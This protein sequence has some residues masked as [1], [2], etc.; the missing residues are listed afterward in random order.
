[1]PQSDLEVEHFSESLKGKKLDVLVSGSIGAIESVRF[2]RAL[3]RLGAQV[4][5]ILSKGASRFVG[6]DALSWAAGGGS[7]VEEFSG[8]FSHLASKDAMVIA[9]ASANA[10]SSLAH[11]LIDFPGYA[12]AASY[13]GLG[14]PLVLVPSMHDSLFTS[15]FI[16]EN[17]R[18][19]S[20]VASVLKSRAEEGKQKFPE[21]MDLADEVSHILN[22][23]WQE[24]AI[25]RSK[26]VAVSMGSTRAYLDDIRYVSNYSSGKLGSLIAEELYRNGCQTYVIAGSCQVYPRVFTE[27]RRCE[28][29]AEMESGIQ[30]ILAKQASAAVCA[31]S[32][33]DFLPS[34]KIPG[35]IKSREHHELS[36]T[37]QRTHKIIE[38][39][40]PRGRVKVGFKLESHLTPEDARAYAFEYMVKYDLSMMVVNRLSDVSLDKH[41]AFIYARNHKEIGG[42]I[43]LKSKEEV[44]MA[45]A[46]HVCSTLQ[47]EV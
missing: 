41:K 35:K 47:M 19:V 45:V 33:L 22:R 1:M 21:P 13:L 27:L 20:S 38:N 11:G 28:T 8:Q 36:I 37:M 46:S 31:A 14:R 9:P 3:R 2:I 30:E 40:H 39:L 24:K 5:P 16:T 10:V 42:P 17:L 18:K 26:G 29:N 34:A 12:L 44:A 6:A 7:V 25:T 23:K 4:Y 32:V 15:P 43:L